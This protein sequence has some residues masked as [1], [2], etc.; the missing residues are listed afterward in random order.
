MLSLTTF[1]YSSKHHLRVVCENKLGD[2]DK[3][4]VDNSPLFII[5]GW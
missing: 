4:G 1:G 2:Q 3:G 5:F